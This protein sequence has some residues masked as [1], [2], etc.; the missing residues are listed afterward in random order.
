M[1]E[2]NIVIPAESDY[3][4]FGE[5]TEEVDVSS[6][7]EN[8]RKKKEREGKNYR[9]AKPGDKD[10]PSQEALKRAQG[11][12]K[13]KDPVTG[14]LFYFER[15]FKYFKFPPKFFLNNK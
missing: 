11:A 1:T 2:A 15:I 10:R 3:G 14:E 9:P 13:Y 6:L 7:W 5:D 12:F 8:I 4:D